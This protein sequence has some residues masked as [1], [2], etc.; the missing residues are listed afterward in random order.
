MIIVIIMNQDALEKFR[1]T[2]QRRV[3][4]EELAKVSTHP[5][6]DEVHRMVR[7]RLPR[8]S[9]GTVYRNLEILSGRG[10]ILKLDGVGSQR[11]Y[12]GDTKD[13]LHVRCLGCG[14]VDDLPVGPCADIEKKVR[15]GTDYEIVGYSLNFIGYCPRCARRRRGRSR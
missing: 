2:R 6:A 9:L 11:R 1:M 7:R 4:L 12:D 3:I 10:M 8:V 14:R 5:T 13:H 15:A